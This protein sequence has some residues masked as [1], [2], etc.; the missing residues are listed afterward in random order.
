M[1]REEA[2]RFRD[3]L[4][5]II[6][7]LDDNTALDVF[8]LFLPWKIGVNYYGPPTT[9]NDPP[10]SRV[11]YGDTLYKCLQSHSSQFG[12]EPNVAVSLWYPIDNP[13][14]EW[15]EWVQPIGAG[16]GYPLNA[17]VSHN[18]KHWINVGKDDNEYEPGV[19]GW[20]EVPIEE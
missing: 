3:H 16:T 6:E 8:D 13:A 10:Q 12:W 18:G 11:Q 9:S 17:Q 5:E 15:P 7:A 20:N 4:N 1:T 19:W 2:I 14:E